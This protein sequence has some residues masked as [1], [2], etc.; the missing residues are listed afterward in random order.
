MHTIIL[1][2]RF[3][4]DS[5]RDLF[6]PVLVHKRDR[7]AIIFS[8]HWKLMIISFY[9]AVVGIVANIVRGYQDDIRISIF[10]NFLNNTFY[11]FLKLLF[12]KSR[13][14]IV[15]CV[16]YE[17]AIRIVVKNVSPQPV[18]AGISRIT[19]YA[20]INKLESAFG[21]LYAFPSKNR[22]NPS[23]PSIP[24]LKNR[25]ELLWWWAYRLWVYL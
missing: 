23:R 5:I 25:R 6:L 4:R 21:K 3:E 19:G 14:G 10:V 18:Q 8:Q 7:N 13:K 11:I 12:C 20:A 22:Y 16:L 9:L 17:N 2:Q 24:A 15:D 1:H